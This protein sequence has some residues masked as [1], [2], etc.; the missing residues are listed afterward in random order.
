MLVV[1]VCRGGSCLLCR[2][3]ST[4]LHVWRRG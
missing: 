4:G 3:T 2:I 1:V